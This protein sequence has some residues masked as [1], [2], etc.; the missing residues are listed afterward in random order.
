MFL[1]FMSLGGKRGCRDRWK[2]YKRYSA[3]GRDLQTSLKRW[4]RGKSAHLLLF[5]HLLLPPTRASPTRS[6]QLCTSSASLWRSGSCWRP[7]FR[8]TLT[9]D[10]G[11]LTSRSALSKPVLQWKHLWRRKSVSREFEVKIIFNHCH[12]HINKE[13]SQLSINDHKLYKQ[14]FGPGVSV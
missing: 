4:F 5:R 7:R 6:D 9:L 1:L 3:A 8:R 2:V 11:R 12:S 13:H 10:P 14:S